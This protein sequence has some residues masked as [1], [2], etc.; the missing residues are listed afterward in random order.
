MKNIA[1]YQIS[2]IFWNTHLSHFTKSCYFNV[3]KT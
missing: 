3:W 1:Q 2:Y